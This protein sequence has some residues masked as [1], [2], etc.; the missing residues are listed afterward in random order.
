MLILLFV[1][2]IFAFAIFLI[3]QGIKNIKINSAPADVSN[4]RPFIC[5]VSNTRKKDG[6]IVNGDCEFVFNDNLFIIKQNNEQIENE[7]ES[8]YYVDIWEYKDDTFFKIVMRSH[9]EYIF[10]SIHFEADKISEFLGK[11][12]I[13][14]EDNRQ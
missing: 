3:I 2:L 4:L 14:I 10:K 1:I 6:N 8:I 13:K 5:S 12:G 11:K 9:T 7:I